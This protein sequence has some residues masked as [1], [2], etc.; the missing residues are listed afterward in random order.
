MTLRCFMQERNSKH[1]MKSFKN[2][3][4]HR[5]YKI[6]N[7]SKLCTL[8]FSNKGSMGKSETFLNGMPWLCVAQDITD[9]GEVSAGYS[10]KNGWELPLV[11]EKNTEN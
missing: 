11:V 7:I 3:Y 5:L 1:I 10:F 6:S 9:C 8:S 2:A 4:N